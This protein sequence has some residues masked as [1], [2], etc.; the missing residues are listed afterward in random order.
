[1]QKSTNRPCVALCAALAILFATPVAALSSS[2]QELFERAETLYRQLEV[3]DPAGQ[4]GSWGRV[5][6]AFSDVASRF[7]D[8]PLASEAL[9]RISWIYGRQAR[10]GDAAAAGRQLQAYRDLVERYPASPHAP[11][12]LL[13]LAVEAEGEGGA[14]A[15]SLY[16][17]LLQS[18]SSTPQAALARNRMAEVRR[19]NP[20]LEAPADAP[21]TSVPAVPAAATE[22]HA[23]L[24]E[25]APVAAETPLPDDY[26]AHAA[27]LARLTGVRHYS[28][29]AHTRVVLDL[30]RPVLYSTGAA[31]RPERLFIDLQGVGKPGA[32][33]GADVNGAEQVI[34]VSKAVSRVRVGQNRPGVVRVVIDLAG[35]SR[36]T[37]FTLDNDGEPFRVVIDVPTATVA[38]RLNDAR[39]PPRVEGDSIAGQL[40]L[41]VRRVVIDPGHGGTDPGAIGRTGA[42]EKQLTL[43]LSKM[44]A[45]R[46]RAAGY[47][48]LLTRED[49]RTISL[50]ERTDFANRVDADLF[51]SVHINSARNRNLR[52][53][54][55]YYLDLANDPAARE[56]AARENASG[57]GGSM[58][59]LGATL[60]HIVNNEFRGASSELAASIQDSLVMHVSKSYQNV[61]D[62]GVKTAPF[63]VLVG[64]KMPAVLIETSF[65]SNEQEEGWLKTTAYRSQLAEA[66]EIG[67]QAYV[68]KRKVMAAAGR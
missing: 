65:V 48:V 4:S 46:L 62:L 58:A 23:P 68:E 17:R 27:D 31:H 60:Q 54:E 39:R 13:R 44:L 53:F 47:E 20:E 12:A 59:D 57:Q 61:H 1:M 32:L 10:G 33:A 66:I 28:D 63:S 30:D 38:S 19:A 9:W 50:Q 36:H 51:L 11:E 41:G 3:V 7:P 16:A 37:L 45:G 15:A 6:D 52:G 56:T 2:P 42:T 8:S 21:R 26:D 43:E 40:G 18:Y 5:A 67:L 29:P 24:V 64:A 22:G 55:T 34:A 49:D 35:D 25:P 14:R